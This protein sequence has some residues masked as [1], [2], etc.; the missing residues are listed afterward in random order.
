MTPLLLAPWLMVERNLVWFR[1]SP[2]I[3]LS[4]ALEPFIF[5]FGLGVGLGAIVGDV[6]WNGEIL[7]Y[8]EFVAPALVATSAMTGAQFEMSFN[9]Y[10]KLNESGTFKAILYSP[11][12]LTNIYDGE[13]M[14]AM[15][16]G[17]LYSIAFVLAMWAFGLLASAW[18]ILIPFAALLVG[19]SFAG[20]ASWAT[21]HVRHWQ[22]FDLF[23]LVTQPLFLLS[24]T[25]FSLDVYPE[26]C[27]PIVQATPLYQGVDL[28]RDLARG[29]VDLSAVGHVAYLV[30]M[31]VVTR[32]LTTRRLEV[33]LKN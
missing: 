28:I 25:F 5:L 22:D 21:T 19:L 23:F 17:G 12:R 9:F 10:F 27:R 29:T 2:L 32:R 14:W 13:L 18:A 16:R 26:W 6:E 33:L 4:G 11:M 8:P 7:T 30:V 1:R 20:L 24:T 15:L 3:L 31:L